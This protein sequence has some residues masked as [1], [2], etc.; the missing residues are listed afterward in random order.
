MT[1]TSDSLVDLMVAALRAADIAGGNIWS[2]RD[3]PT[4][5]VDN[6]IVLLDLPEE[7][8]TSLGRS[9]GPQFTVVATVTL[10][11]RLDRLAEP[12]DMGALRLQADL[13]VMRRAIEVAVINDPDLFA[14][15]QQMTFVRSSL[16]IET[17]ERHLGDLQMQFGLEFYQGLDDF[18]QPPTED[19]ERLV[20]EATGYP[21]AGLDLDLTA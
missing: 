1:T 13:S 2:Y 21:G 8:K 6:P 17:K 9:G 19:L 12:G 10:T 16:K 7:D 20:V 18:H 5:A 14:Q 4:K 15:I 11:A 3:W